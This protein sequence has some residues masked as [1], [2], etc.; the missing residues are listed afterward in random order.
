MRYLSAR[1]RTKREVENYLDERQFDEVTVQETVDRL[2]ELGLL[3]D[4]RFAEE[5]VQ[6]RLRTKPISRASLSRQLSAHFV[7]RDLIESAL[8]YVTPEMERGNCA[9]VL[10]KYRRQLDRLPTEERNERI[11]QRA[12]SRGFMYSDIALG[13][14]QMRNEEH[15]DADS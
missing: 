8:T 12:V 13:M 2:M 9:S 3:D 5:F 6:S 11:R 1:A 10:R 14:E 15:S 4:A 7:P